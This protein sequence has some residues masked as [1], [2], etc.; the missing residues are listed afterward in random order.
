MT[1]T[2]AV[3]ASMLILLPGLTFL[4]VWN[5]KGA[6]SGATRP[7]LP[8]G[9]ATTL[10]LAV[11]ISLL[12]HFLGWAL[13][14][15]VRNLFVAIPDILPAESTM[16]P[17]IETLLRPAGTYEP[18]V[19]NPIEAM[20]R[21]A[22]GGHL[23]MHELAMFSGLVLLESMLVAKFVS[24]DGFDLVFDGTDLNGQGWVYHH[25]LRP[26]QHSYRPICHVLTTF[27]Q[28]NLGI[29]YIGAIADI[30]HSEKGELLSLA[31]LN[32]D[33]FLFQLK[34]AVPGKKWGQSAE[35]PIFESYGREA[36]GGVVA[37]DGKSVANLLVRTLDKALLD[38]I[39]SQTEDDPI[40]TPA[41]ETGAPE[42]AGKR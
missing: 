41:S 7:E 34:T 38:D 25:Y 35:E 28:N 6:R 8:L 19:A 32:P 10:L 9:S 17:P 4:G 20:V 11:G 26:S 36:I 42:P 24:N 33:R 23:Q 13:V 2:L 22:D 5:L 12:A 27:Q 39:E 3:L 30:R 15:L 21:Y 14:E 18:I 1:L 40:T 29:G 16:W 31:L 37:L